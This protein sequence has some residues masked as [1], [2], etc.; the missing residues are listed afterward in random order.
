MRLVTTLRVAGLAI[1]ASLCV[2]SVVVSVDVTG[3]AAASTPPLP[4]NDAFYAAPANLDSYPNGA[5]VRFRAGNAAVAFVG[6]ALGTTSWQLA[7]R[8]NDTQGHPIM[9]VTTILVPHGTYTGGAVLRPLVTYQVAE[10]SLGLQCAPSYSLQTGANRLTNVEQSVM[11][12]ALMRGY[13]L[14]IPDYEGPNSAELAGVQDAHIILDSVRAAKSFTPAGLSPQTPTGLWGYSAAGMAT[15]WAAELQPSYAPDLAIAGVA[16]GGAPYSLVNSFKRMDGGPFMSFVLT[17]LVGLMKAYPG[18]DVMSQFNPAGK[19]MVA[20]IDGT[21]IAD[22][23]FSYPFRKLDDFTLA[24]SAIDV[25]VNKAFLAA[26]SLG[27]FI[28]TVPLYTYF[29]P[30]DEAVPL[31]DSL[32]MIDK[33]CAGGA[34]VVSSVNV[35]A[36]HV[37]AAVTS[38]PGALDFL[39]ARFKGERLTGACH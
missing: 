22:I 21:C 37:I 10:D 30:F 13:A 18:W 23:G 19:A 31:E 29:T 39:D 14:N 4:A 9:A 3:S 16:F 32:T 36:D 6:F 33:Y 26:G 15:A 25:P 27:H 20:A 38:A 35:L 1:A 8:S 2:A 28:P 11:A 24:R 7:F 34:R 17:G 12:L 5:I